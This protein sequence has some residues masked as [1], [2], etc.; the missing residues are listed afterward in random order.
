MRLRASLKI[1]RNERPILRLLQY[2]QID[3]SLE[4]LL[5]SALPSYEV[6]NEYFWED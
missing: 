2:L 3:K 4:I 6:L 5:V 1:E